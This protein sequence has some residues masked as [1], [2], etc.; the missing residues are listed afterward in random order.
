MY[1][2]QS[3]NRFL[4]GRGEQRMSGGA[5][6]KGVTDGEVAAF[7]ERAARVP[8]P[9]TAAT[10]DDGPRGRLIFAMDAT[11]SR[12][13]GWDMACRIQGEM[14]AATKAIGG[15]DVQLVYFRGF[16]ECKAG[17]W[18]R[19]A[20]GL[21][22]LMSGVRCRAGTTQIDKVLRHAAREAARAPV[23]AL[24][25]VGDAFEENI[26]T[27]CRD[28]GE[29]GLLGVPAFMFQEGG[30]PIAEKSFREIARLTGGAYFPFDPGSAE[31]LKA[32]LTAAAVYAAGGRAALADHGRRG[33]DMLRLLTDRMADGMAKKGG[34]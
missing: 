12:E 34:G 28:A 23:G 24:V 32:L 18:Q 6:R 20:A 22:R 33:N 14:F 25:V 5:I 15:L 10:G 16:G 3:G 30:D 9:A 13:P 26:D 1:G 2:F 11:M 27:T 29:L 8:A 17:K 19:D 21:A 4:T 7:L 31:R